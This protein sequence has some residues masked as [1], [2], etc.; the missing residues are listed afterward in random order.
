M[1]RGLPKNVKLALSKATDSALL[2]VESYNKPAIKFRSGGYIVLMQIAWTALFHAIFFRS[3]IKPFHRKKNSKRFE[4]RDGDYCYWELE[5]CLKEYYKTDTTNPTRVNLEFFIPLRNKIEHKS[6]P[7]IDGSI[8]AECQASLLN[9]DSLIYKE[10]DEKY[11]LKES[12][13]FS[14]QLFPSSKNLVDAVKANPI[15]K[16]VVNFINEYRSSL[17]QDILES[18]QYS[19]K[20]FLFQVANHNSK[21]SLPI[22]FYKYDELSDDEKKNVGRVAAL[23]K[24]KVVERNVSGKDLLLPSEVVRQVQEGLGNPKIVKNGEEKDK[25]NLYVHSQCWKYYDIRPESK[26]KTPNKTK[27]KYCIYDKKDKNYGYT[28][29]WVQKLTEELKI[30]GKLEEILANKTHK[31]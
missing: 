23:I 17:S 12:L 20:A 27:S 4:K 10:F 7:E 16:N 8:F 6:L 13:S 21:E 11:C 31:Q 3:K 9:F 30:K 1:P 2:A 15:S 5:T 19:F 29:E 14:L 18:G 28:P 25:F 24:E 22:Q 26:S